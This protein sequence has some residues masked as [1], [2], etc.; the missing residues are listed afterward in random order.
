VSEGEP[1]VFGDFCGSAGWV[2]VGRVEAVVTGLGAIEV[3]EASELVVEAADVA[4]VVE[5]VVPVEASQDTTASAAEIAIGS[6]K[7]LRIG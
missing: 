7:G 4:P 2:G 3:V 1:W 5:E 6:R